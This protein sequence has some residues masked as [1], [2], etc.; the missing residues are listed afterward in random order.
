[1]THTP[2]P[3]TARVN[4][5]DMILPEDQRGE[6]LAVTNGKEVVCQATEANA[7]LIAAAPELLEALKNLTNTIT[8]NG[9]TVARLDA[10]AFALNVIAK[11]EGKP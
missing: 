11:A 10:T 8:E 2:G 4:P 7:R 6:K 9:S 5:W 3:W 1:M